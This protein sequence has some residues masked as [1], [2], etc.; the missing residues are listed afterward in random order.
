MAGRVRQRTQQHNVKRIG[1]CGGLV[2]ERWVDFS[3]WQRENE[4]INRTEENVNRN[5]G[6]SAKETVSHDGIRVGNQ[7][8]RNRGS[9]IEI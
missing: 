8:R 2:S 5:A 4:P 7:R 6:V 9:F 1:A 3:V